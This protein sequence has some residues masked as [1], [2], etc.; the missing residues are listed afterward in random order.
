MATSWIDGSFI[1]GPGEVWSNC[2]REFRDGRL[3]PNRN[4]P[5]FPASNDIGLPL[6]NFPD[7]ITNKLLNTKTLWS[8][9]LMY[10]T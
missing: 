7:P 5:L 9:S 3:K 1:Y 10:K 2:L 8:K 6:Q 4:N